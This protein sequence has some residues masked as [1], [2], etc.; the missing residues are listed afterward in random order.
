MEAKPN[1][2]FNPYKKLCPELI[3]KVLKEI[4]EGSTH[5]YACEVNGITERILSMWR[6]QGVV[7]LEYENE[8]S[9]PAKLIMGLA[10]IKNKEVKYCRNLIKN[11][12]KGH[13]GAEWT[14]ER[15][16]WKYFGAKAETLEMAE[17]I[18][19]LKDGLRND[20]GD[21]K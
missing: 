15:A 7:D 5:K 17:E 18:Q 6:A 12:E 9:L 1:K 19:K 2:K 3:D 8:D 14:L 11:N 13:K 20:Q 21:Q 10:K 4:S 16:Y